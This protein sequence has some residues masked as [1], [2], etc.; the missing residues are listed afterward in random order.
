MTTSQLLTVQSKDPESTV[1]LSDVWSVLST[2][3]D[4]QPLMS[5]AGMNGAI[6]HVKL[7]RVA[8]GGGG[9]SPALSLARS[10]DLTIVDSVL[11]MDPGVPMI[12]TSTAPAQLRIEGGALVVDS[13]DTLIISHDGTVPK[14]LAQLTGVRLSLHT[15]AED[16]QA[17][18]DGCTIMDAPAKTRFK[19]WRKPARAL[20]VPAHG[21]LVR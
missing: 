1:S 19:S 18:L 3:S 12:R 5:F 14:P 4:G 20:Q 10:K 17:G 2:A 21:V 6:A 15:P 16:H 9:S 11:V 8:I 13:P 7:E